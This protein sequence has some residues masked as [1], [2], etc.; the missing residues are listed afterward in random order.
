MAV[1]A[2]DGDTIQERRA[3]PYVLSS[4]HLGRRLDHSS[5]DI[6]TRATDQDEATRTRSVTRQW[7]KRVRYRQIMIWRRT[8]IGALVHTLPTPSFVGGSTDQ[9]GMAAAGVD[10][11]AEDELG[12]G[13]VEQA[14]GEWSAG[15]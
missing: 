11:H 5:T 9:D 13:T 12:G 3:S 8:R 4:P 6:F 15:R 10:E 1:H 14:S 7:N 2:G